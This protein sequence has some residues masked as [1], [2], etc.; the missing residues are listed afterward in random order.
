MKLE[1]VN[2]GGCGSQTVRL[3]PMLVFGEQEADVF[4]KATQ[5]VLENL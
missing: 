4:V 5:R 1:G 3:R 2:V